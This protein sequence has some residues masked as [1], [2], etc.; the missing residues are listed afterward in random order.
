MPNPDGPLVNRDLSDGIINTRL[1]ASTGFAIPDAPVH[2]Q[3]FRASTSTGSLGSSGVEAT[4]IQRRNVAM[5]TGSPAENGPGFVF[6]T[7]AGTRSTST[8]LN[9]DHQLVTSV[10]APEVVSAE[11]VGAMTMSLFSE[12][13]D[14]SIDP[15]MRVFYN[16]GSTR[17]PI[18]DFIDINVTANLVFDTTNSG[19]ANVVVTS[20]GGLRR[21][22]SA[23][24]YKPG[25]SYTTNLADRQLPR[26]IVWPTDT[27]GSRLGYGA[28]HVA[29]YVPEA[30]AFEQYHLAGIVAVL[31][32]KVERLERERDD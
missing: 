12:A 24:Q 2:A 22:A 9:D 11:G 21:N 27:G 18:A 25:W 1:F 29:A 15:E 32:D 31:Q 14:D 20:T 23:L 30:A 7:V 13:A 26:P 19:T 16:G 10:I 28:E 4:L 5:Y 3:T 8:G 17:T 6:A